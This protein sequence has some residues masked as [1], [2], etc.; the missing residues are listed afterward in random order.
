[1]IGI[2]FFIMNRRLTRL[3][4]VIVVVADA[5]L[6]VEVRWSSP[7]S[8]LIFSQRFADL[9]FKELPDIT[10]LATLELQATLALRCTPLQGT[11]PEGFV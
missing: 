9:T 6:Q 7:L 10:R 1:M 11:P 2:E 4:H 5:L 8:F 3:Q